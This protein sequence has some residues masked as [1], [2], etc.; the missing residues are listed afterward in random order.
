MNEASLAIALILPLLVLLAIGVPVAFSLAFVSLAGVYFLVGPQALSVVGSIAWGGLAN[1][2]LTPL[3]LFLLMGE[4]VTIGAIGRDLFEMA[5]RWLAR[6]PGGLAVA[7]T[8]ACAVFG[9]MCGVSIGAVAAIGPAALEQMES[10]GY[11][12]KLSLGAIASAGS[13]A[14][15]IPPSAPF[16]L[17][18]IVTE[19]SIGDLFI[20]GII[21]G[22]VVASCLAFFIVSRVLIN[23]KLAPP[24]P[25]YTW[26]EIFAA[27]KA[28]WAP[29]LLI[30]AVLGTIYSGIATPSESAAI[31]VV[32]AF[33][34][35]L[36]R[37]FDLK[38]AGHI[39]K[40]VALTTGMIGMILVGAMMY[41]YLLNSQQIPQFISSVAT[42]L[43][44]SP[45]IILFT[46]QFILMILGCFLDVGSCI[47]ITMPIFVPIIQQLGFD[48]I[49]FGVTV[50]INME[51][52]V[53]T[54]PVGLNLYVLLGVSPSGV[55]L[56]DII[57]GVLPYIGVLFCALAIIMIFPQISL[58]LPGLMHAG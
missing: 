1:F 43:E 24:V 15:L 25:G 2:L 3:P 46:I 16:I 44:V 45:W 14:M 12:R 30:L 29:L 31:G 50:I 56:K 37:K 52:A 51:I 38:Q 36:R 33:L 17:Y 21:P 40:D 28:A 6:L 41:G 13:M 4:F 54:P 8:Y 23:R 10:R 34:V 35:S 49:W 55:T 11:D 20:A 42:S 57:F 26:G 7:S 5:H 18:G 19:T 53:V 9:A 48:L 39:L 58:W 27:L 32:A 47:M 22:I